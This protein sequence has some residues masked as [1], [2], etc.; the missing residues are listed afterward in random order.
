[1][2]QDQGTWRPSDLQKKGRLPN[3]KAAGVTGCRKVRSCLL[4]PSVSTPVS[5]PGSALVN[6]FMSNLLT[7]FYYLETVLELPPSCF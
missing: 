3:E 6:R 5:H 4:E 2:G 1:M 7:S